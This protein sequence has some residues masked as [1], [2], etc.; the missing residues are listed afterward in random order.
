MSAFHDIA[1][2]YG[3]VDRSDGRAVQ[4]W[5]TEELP[6]LPTS[7]IE[8]VLEELLTLDGEGA[9]EVEAVRVYSER[10]PLPSLASSP[11]APFPLLAAG[12]RKLLS[13]LYGRVMGASSDRR[14]K[15]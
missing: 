12:W 14:R 6:K 11:A 10:R 5:F 7:T 3:G 4:R 13:R 2:K 1:A 9:R 8:A 15:P